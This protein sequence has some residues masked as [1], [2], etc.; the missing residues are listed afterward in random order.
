MMNQTKILQHAAVREIYRRDFDKYAVDCLKIRG[1]V[2]GSILPLNLSPSQRFINS[3][4]DAQERQYGYIRAVCLKP[5]QIGETT[6]GQ[7]R[8]FH[9]ASLTRN[10]Y[11][12]L[13]AHDEVTAAAIFTMCGF[14]Y[15][16]LPDSIRPMTLYNTKDELV[17][18]NPDK[19]TRNRYPGL[20]SRM[21][22]R[23]GNVVKVATG[24]TPHGIHLTETA[25][26]TATQVDFLKASLYHS[27]HLVPGTIFINESTAHVGGSFFR[28]CC[29]MA[30]SGTTPWIF[31]FTPWYLPHIEDCRLPLERGE[32][33]NPTVEE[34]HLIKVAG[35]GQPEYGIAP[36]IITPEHLKWR[37]YKVS[38]AG[39]LGEELFRQEFP[40][41]YDDCWIDLSQC[42]FDPVKLRS[43]GV[44]VKPPTR[45]ATISPGPH[46]LDTDGVFSHETD[47]CAIWEDP[48]PKVLYDIGVDVASGL[49]SGDWS[50]AEV[51][52]RDTGEQVA[53]LHVHQDPIDFADAL[54][55]LGTYYNY[56][57]LI[58]ETNSIGLPV[59]QTLNRRGYCNVYFWRQRDT[60]TPKIT[61]YTGWRT[62]SDSK[63]FLI[64]LMR[65]KIHRQEIV[66]RSRVLM[67]EMEHFIVVPRYSGEGY[68]AGQGHD[69]ATMAFGLAL[70]GGYD[71]STGVIEVKSPSGK[72]RSE[73]IE[74]AIRL[75]RCFRP[76]P[77]RDFG[78]RDPSTGTDRLLKVL[79][80]WE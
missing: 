21:A 49:H 30:R 53:E 67:N 56:A 65:H 26:L 79:E 23:S 38:E 14:F 76:D 34:R 70:I 58:V 66:I 68:E 51:V 25:K 64:A 19:K 9:R 62:T 32:S 33:L 22:F 40:L 60:V 61:K 10:F 47:Y 39:T 4:F 69:D 24:T 57:Q 54:F 5:R 2:P 37:R 7:A 50:V 1:M 78:S 6:L 77:K 18:A 44:G 15:K 31:I 42:A 72:S 28:E 46:V 16:N 20:D 13:V 8:M 41:L 43:L 48:Q 3:R 74:E 17:F 27:I 55:W 80:G 36:F 11:S 29:D 59:D 73:Q 52:R 63:R 75:E 45:L 71:E 12:L 35:Q